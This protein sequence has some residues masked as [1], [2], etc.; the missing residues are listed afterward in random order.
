[1]LFLV[2]Y[3][4]EQSRADQAQIDGILASIETECD[5]L[6][7]AMKM[8]TME[9]FVQ[10]TSEET[11]KLLELP[12]ASLTRLTQL[13]SSHLISSSTLPGDDG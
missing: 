13:I 12:Y 2:K 5:M 3:K 7:L 4:S 8:P 10:S 1:M 6:T 11:A 9:K